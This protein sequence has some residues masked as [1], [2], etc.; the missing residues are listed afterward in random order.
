MLE[1]HTEDSQTRHGGVVAR[2]GICCSRGASI[3]CLAT[4]MLKPA[5]T[6]IQIIHQ[7]KNCARSRFCG[8]Y[9]YFIYPAIFQ[10]SQLVST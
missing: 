6:H 8:K 1:R 10:T 4:T 2:H 3:V 5:R 9:I 7:R